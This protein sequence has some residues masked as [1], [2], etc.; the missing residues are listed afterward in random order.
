VT[1]SSQAQLASWLAKHPGDA[2]SVM[3][4]T[5][6]DASH[7]DYVSREDVAEALAVHGW[8]AGRRYTL[9][10]DLLGHMIAKASA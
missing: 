9:N 10:A 7:R 3:L 5:H 8:S 6:V 1:I 4:V 2:Q